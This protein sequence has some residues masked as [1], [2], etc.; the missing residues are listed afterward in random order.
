MRD[1]TN[2]DRAEWASLAVKDHACRTNS[3]DE[4]AQTKLSDLLCNLRHFADVIGIDWDS[5]IERASMHYEA[6]AENEE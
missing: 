4:D 1:P 5:A 3:Q 2:Y 6:E